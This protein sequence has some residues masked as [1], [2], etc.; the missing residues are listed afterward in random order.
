M[1]L[2]I[3][4]E[5]QNLLYDMIHKTAE[6]KTVFSTIDEKNVWFRDVIRSFF[7]QLP[8]EID[9][10]RLKQVN[11]EAL[12]YMVNYLKSKN[13]EKQPLFQEKPLTVLKREQPIEAAQYTSF[14]DIPKP[15]PIDFSEK[16]NDDIITNMDELIEQQKKMR[17]RELQEYAPQPPLHNPSVSPPVLPEQTKLKILE[18]LPKTAIQEKHVHFSAPSME[19]RMTAIENKIDTLLEIFRS[20]RY[21]SLTSRLDPPRS[22]NGLNDATPLKIYNGTPKDVPQGQQLPIHEWNGTHISGASPTLHRSTV[23][24]RNPL[25][26]ENT[27]SN[28]IDAENPSVEIIKQLIKENV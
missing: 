17:E 20:P 25:K 1:S 13:T 8:P 5:N 7:N 23:E 12:G 26:I 11:R 9:R 3:S 10:E 27:L 14:Y 16:L 21:P 19:Q 4:V 24:Q 18:D 15:K 22:S 2:F 6:I 28:R